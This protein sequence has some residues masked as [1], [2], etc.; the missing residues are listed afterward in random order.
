VRHERH[1]SLDEATALLPWVS[2]TLAGMREAQTRLTD[3]DARAALAGGAVSNGGG[4]PGRQ[5]GE[6]FVALQQG[7]GRLSEREVILR[8]LERGLIDFPAVRDGEEVYLCWVDG[9]P[10]IAF[11]HGLDAGFAGRRPL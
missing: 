6:A 5:V 9:E 4:R 10:E 8:D 3:Q 11:W 1:Y 7:L 2:S